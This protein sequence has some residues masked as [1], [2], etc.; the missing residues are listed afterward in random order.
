MK[1]FFKKLYYKLYLRFFYKNHKIYN[2]YSEYPFLE[3]DNL[4]VEFPV[5]AYSD[6]E[7][8]KVGQ[9]L[10]DDFNKTHNSTINFKKVWLL[11]NKTVSITKKNGITTDSNS[12]IKNLL[13]H[14]FKKH[15]NLENLFSINKTHV[16]KYL[17]EEHQFVMKKEMPTHSSNKLF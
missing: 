15:P 12:Y 8:S 10:I 14:D 6:E 2:I 9:M 11:K 7:A 5:I 17:N 4:I 1:L 16:F 3:N 13:L